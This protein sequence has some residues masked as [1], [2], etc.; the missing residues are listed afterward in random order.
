MRPVISNKDF[1][2]EF[3]FRAAGLAVCLAAILSVAF[4]HASFAQGA[5][6]MTPESE[7]K[8]SDI[9]DAKKPSESYCTLTRGFTKNVVLTIA[10]NQRDETSLAFDFRK[11][12]FAPGKTYTVAMNAGP[13]ARRAFEARPVSPSALV[14][15][16]GK[17]ETF[18]AGVRKSGKLD[19]SIS[20]NIYSFA[21]DG[22]GTAMDRLAT[23]VGELR[24]ATAD[25]L[26]ESPSSPTVKK[27][28]KSSGLSEK[29][30]KIAMPGVPKSEVAIL[31]EE[32][33]RLSETLA[34]ERRSY[35][36]SAMGA[37]GSNALTELREKLVLLEK[38]NTRLRQ[39]RSENSESALNASH[40]VQTDQKLAE[41]IST[42]RAENTRLRKVLAE[43]KSTKIAVPETVS[44]KAFDALRQQYEEQKAKND[45]L[46]KDLDASRSAASDA[47]VPSAEAITQTRILEEKLAAAEKR[48]ET[49]A[50]ESSQLRTEKEKLLLKKSDNN[51]DA[52]EATRRY[53]EADREARRLSL[54]LD[55]RTSA[56]NEEKAK[57][58]GLLFDPAVTSSAQIAHLADLEE[59]LQK[60]RSDLGASDSICEGK[61]AQAEKE[62]GG[63]TVESLKKQIAQMESERDALK[64]AAKE[65]GEALARAASARQEIASQKAS[66]E[67]KISELEAALKKSAATLSDSVADREAAM[68][69]AQSDA[70]RKIKE[71]EAALSL[72]Q[73]EKTDLTASLAETRKTLDS[74]SATHQEIASQKASY[75]KKISE[76]EAALKKS[77]ATLSDSVAD[78][79][80]AMK[81]AQSDVARKIKE[82]EAALSLLHKEKTDLVARISQLE[83]ER[84]A[85]K[86][87]ASP[88]PQQEKEGKKT[89]EILKADMNGKEASFRETVSRLEAEKIALARQVQALQAQSAPAPQTTS[90][91]V[92]PGSK[93][94][95]ELE[96]LRAE[97]AR[98]DLASR[99]QADS[100]KTEMDRK[101]AILESEKKALQFALSQIG[102]AGGASTPAAQ[103]VRPQPPAR[104]ALPPDRAAIPASFPGQSTQSRLSVPAPRTAPFMSAS[105]VTALLNSANLSMSSRVESVTPA[106]E[107]T[108]RAFRW[109]SGPLFGS[110]EERPIAAPEQF[111]DF[112]SD[113]L[114]RTRSHCTGDFASSSTPVPTPQ[115]IEQASSYEI[116]CVSPGGGSSAAVLF[117]ARKGVFSVIANESS[118]ESIDTAIEA[119]DRIYTALSSLTRN[120]ME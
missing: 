21:I 104:V 26:P 1:F 53:N 48:V 93:T 111:T 11:D 12:A 56:C 17:D 51:W 80:A 117:V 76:L 65:S 94:A 101:I 87:V 92:E 52:E 36:N 77:A 59:Q 10:S 66:Y 63:K 35:E 62:S 97:I 106:M 98:K 112:V 43:E 3:P 107:T 25:R 18:Y 39:G 84:I 78:R 57:L 29:P 119:R 7:W 115:G 103:G 58:E 60:A 30:S 20:G 75:E 13:G 72:L 2:L 64:T 79:E 120:A 55:E 14:I 6:P 85:E 54:L 88:L 8:L 22:L 99:Q 61:I 68:K 46:K 4:T 16:T 40:P 38:E 91:H 82:Q 45:R 50:Q 5:A 33:R 27:D 44:P 118:A 15:T 69:T 109:E 9:R 100:A 34:Q 19:V 114:D 31:Q 70:A 71:Q 83:S 86:A 32:N 42:L 24:Q 23:C 95:Q 113:Y 37:A 28:I 81:T 105:N 110:L 47:A 49:L 41:D 67:K 116:A 73:K 108:A 96:A 102:S 89:S 74:M 90:P